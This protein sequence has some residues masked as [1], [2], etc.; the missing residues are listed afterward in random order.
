M[1][2]VD[3]TTLQQTLTAFVDALRATNNAESQRKDAAVALES[4]QKAVD[5]A[6]AAEGD[7]ETAAAS[8]GAEVKAAIDAALEAITSEQ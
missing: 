8:A 4:A 5:D 6:Q 1:A 7:T 3:V 2:Q